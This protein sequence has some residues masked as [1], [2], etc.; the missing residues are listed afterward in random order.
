L[1]DKLIGK[2]GS[3]FKWEQWQKKESLGSRSCQ[4]YHLWKI[5]MEEYLY[6]NNLFLPLGGIEN[7]LMTMKDEE[8]DVL[9]KKELGTIWLFLVVSVVFNISK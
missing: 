7:K 8:W 1:D 3:W 5:K 6:Q 2:E 9:D 4:N